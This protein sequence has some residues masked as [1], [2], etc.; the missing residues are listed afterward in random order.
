MNLIRLCGL[1]YIQV[2]QQIPHKFGVGWELIVTVLTV[3]QLR[4][5]GVPEPVVSVEDRSKEGIV[6]L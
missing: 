5:P 6:S 4:T 2:E 1:I 3:L